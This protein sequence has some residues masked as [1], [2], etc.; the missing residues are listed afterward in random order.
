MNNKKA[1]V[2]KMDEMGRKIQAGELEKVQA[3]EETIRRNV[4]AVI[5]FSNETRKGVLELKTI[6]DALQN[7]MINLQKQ[8]N[9][10]KKQLA[11]LQG[12]FY[13]RGSTSYSNGD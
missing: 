2:I 8:F 9:E 4:K 13:K 11:I 3:S 6:V 12:E 10:T 7:N 5:E 1:K